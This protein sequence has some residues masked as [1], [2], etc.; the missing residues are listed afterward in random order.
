MKKILKFL[1]FISSFNLLALDVKEYKKK[2]ALELA[3]MVKSGEVS[4]KELVNLAFKVIN[5]ENPNINSLIYT[6]YEEAIQEAENIDNNPDLLKPFLGVP[7]V[8]KGFGHEITGSP[9]DQGYTFNKGNIA[10]SNS[11]LIKELLKLGFVVVGTSN[12]P[13]GSIRNVTISKLHG[14]AKNPLNTEYNTGGSSGGSASSISSGMVAIASGSDIGGSIRI[15]AAWNGLIGFKPT[16]SSYSVHFPIVKS[17]EDLEMLFE[18]DK[19]YNKKTIEVDDIKKLK[20]AYSLK[21]FDNVKISEEAKKALLKSINFL[22]EQGFDV[23]EVDYPLNPNDML[24]EYTKV[25]LGPI[26]QLD[27]KLKEKNLTKED[28]DPLTWAI[29]V[30]FKDLTKAEKNDLKSTKNN[31]DAF[32]AIMEKFHEKYPLYITP[33]TALEAPLNIDFFI[34]PEME[35]ILY[36]FENVPKEKRAEILFKQWEPMFKRTPFTLVSNL[37]KEPSITLPVHIGKNNLA[38]E[39][40][41]NAPKNYDKVLI[42]LSKLFEEN[43]LFEMKKDI[44]IYENLNEYAKYIDEFNKIDDHLIDNKKISLSFNAG[45]NLKNNKN[46]NSINFGTSFNNFGAFLDMIK[47]FLGIKYVNDN[48]TSFIRYTKNNNKFVDNY[49]LDLYAKYTKNFILNNNFS[50]NTKLG[51]LLGYTSS[52]L[53]DKRVSLNAMSKFLINSGLDLKYSKN[54]FNIYLSPEFSLDLNKYVLKDLKYEKNKLVKHYYNLELKFGLNKELENMKFSI[55]ADTN[56]N[57]S[58]GIKLSY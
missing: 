27:K 28:V 24:R 1:I 12:F 17:S 50:I 33:T 29:N 3:N 22:K 53:L 45:K 13:E 32:A 5:E 2:T 40:L 43:I 15:P 35:K 56:G 36:N 4:S 9:K 54:G 16:S 31:I 57:I 38:M 41:I 8:L 44:S 39:I 14:I 10:T 30:Y 11:S 58:T 6:R 48:F 7:L 52:A 25:A 46:I 42:K 49:S 34:E 18:N 37:T 19:R 26:P 23:S 47:A 51:L 21:D 55:E 20:I